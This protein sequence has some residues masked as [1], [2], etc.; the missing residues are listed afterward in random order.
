MDGIEGNENNKLEVKEEN[1]RI[2]NEKGNNTPIFP[3]IRVKKLEG[4]GTHAMIF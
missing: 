4:R 1:E 3:K 2:E